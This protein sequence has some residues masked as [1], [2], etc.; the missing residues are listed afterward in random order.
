[1]KRKN[2]L[3]EGLTPAFIFTR[4]SGE[5]RLVIPKAVGMWPKNLLRLF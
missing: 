4:L 5:F 1:M 2:D 3:F